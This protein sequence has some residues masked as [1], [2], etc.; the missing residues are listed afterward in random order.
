MSLS[1]ELLMLFGK[2]VTHDAQGIN[3]RLHFLAA[4]LQMNPTLP[5]PT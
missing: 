1:E 2:N 4:C 3:A 5:K